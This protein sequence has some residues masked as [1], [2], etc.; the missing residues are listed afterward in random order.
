M[1]R[2][3]QLLFWTA[4]A[5]GLALAIYMQAEMIAGASHDCVREGWMPLFGNCDNEP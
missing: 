5:L 2:I 1:P 4:C 3:R